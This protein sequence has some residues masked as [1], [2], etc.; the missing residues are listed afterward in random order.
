MS[1]Y[2]YSWTVDYDK[3]TFPT[4]PHALL[5]KH[6]LLRGSKPKL[7]SSSFRIQKA[8]LSFLPLSHCKVCMHNQAGNCQFRD[9]SLKCFN[10]SCNH[11]PWMSSGKTHKI[12]NRCRDVKEKKE[13]NKQASFDTMGLRH[14][15]LFPI[16]KHKDTCPYGPGW[17]GDMWT[18][19]SLLISSYWQ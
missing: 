4:N 12:I 14:Y 1:T 9:C 19:L 3:Y 7:K 5:S 6:T 2:I 8:S 10:F 18:F 13:F 16:L 17:K 11:K 15:L